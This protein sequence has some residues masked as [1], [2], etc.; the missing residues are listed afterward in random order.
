NT[1]I[2]LLQAD[3]FINPT[4]SAQ[5]AL[6]KGFYANKNGQALLT[7][8][9]GGTTLSAGVYNALFAPTTGLLANGDTNSVLVDANGNALTLSFFS[10]YANVKSFLQNQG[11][12]ANK[13]SIQ[14]LT[15]EFDVFF[16]KIDALSSIYV[17]AIAGM[18]QN[19][20]DSL[21]AHDVSTA[22]GV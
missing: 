5:N 11:S 14:L 17:P 6:D 21:V 16:S 13:L 20:E 1:D 19:L 12:M 4:L 18:P 9:P 8:A 3:V 2:T 7:G 22:S 10:S 15:T